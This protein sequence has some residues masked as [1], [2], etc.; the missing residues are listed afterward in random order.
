MLLFRL[1]WG[2]ITGTRHK[3]RGT[4]CL[5]IQ[6]A[7]AALSHTPL[8]AKS[9]RSG[10]T[11]G[12]L[13][14]GTLAGSATDTGGCG[15][16]QSVVYR[17]DAVIQAVLV[18]MA[19]TRHKCRGTLCLVIQAAFAAL[20]HTPIQER[21]SRSGNTSDALKA[22]TL[23][24]SAT[25]TGSCGEKQS[26]V[27]QTDAVIWVDIAGARHKCRGTEGWQGRDINVAVREAG[28]DATF[29]SRGIFSCTLNRG[30]NHRH[31]N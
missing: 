11:S 17:T 27:Y 28:R 14:A 31:R 1:H 4:L 15:E 12:A 6:A 22:G 16:K 21:S 26:V 20:S 7:F 2:D 8:Q 19:G 24:S 29:M 13:K 23:A 10:N 25:G 3:C 9:S 30:T 5:V 18:D